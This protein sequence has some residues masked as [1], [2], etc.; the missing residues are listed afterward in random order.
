LA[1][2]VASVSIPLISWV[3]EATGEFIWLFFILTVIA[4]IAVFTASCLPS[5]TRRTDSEVREMI[6]SSGSD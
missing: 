3:F 1:L 4:L 6:L 2:G 5:E